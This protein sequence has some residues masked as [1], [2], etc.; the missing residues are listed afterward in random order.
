MLTPEVKEALRVLHPD[1]NYI[2]KDSDDDMW[3]YHLKPVVPT[4]E[5]GVV[6]A[7]YEP[8]NTDVEHKLRLPQPVYSPIVRKSMQDNNEEM[9]LV[10]ERITDE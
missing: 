4:S 9:S 3:V 2:G 10:L 1:A 7:H 6:Y 5:T 8:A